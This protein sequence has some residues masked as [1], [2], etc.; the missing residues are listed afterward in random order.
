MQTSLVVTL[1]KL[2]LSA[3]ETSGMLA[4]NGL[5]RLSRTRW[6]C[7][8]QREAPILYTTTEPVVKASHATDCARRIE[9][10]IEIRPPD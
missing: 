4:G 6:I 3:H 7:G 1:A 8:T 2:P 10:R 9:A 5:E